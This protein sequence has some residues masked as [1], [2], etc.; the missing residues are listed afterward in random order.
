[1]DDEK[2]FGLTGYQMSGNTQYYS[3]DVDRTPLQVKTRAKSKFEPKVLLWV[4]ISE[5]GISEPTI[6][7]SATG[8]SIN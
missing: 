8:M 1:M 2:Y 3:P 6:L 7:N 5:K 4:A